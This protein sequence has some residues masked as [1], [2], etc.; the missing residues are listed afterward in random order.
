MGVLMHTRQNVLPKLTTAF[1]LFVMFTGQLLLSSSV[2]AQNQLFIVVNSQSQLDLNKQQIRNVF[3]GSANNLGLEPV[4]LSTGDLCRTLFNLKV[5]GLTESR[6]QS[7]WAQMR[8]SGRM[9]P[10]K[11][12]DTELEAIAFVSQN[13][14][15]IAYVSSVEA[16]PET[17]KILFVVD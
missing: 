10:P 16:L 17:V 11:E 6:I 12:V 8:F 4:N 13:R 2:S 15:A 14:N 1:A 7:Y 5:V 9:K 3:M